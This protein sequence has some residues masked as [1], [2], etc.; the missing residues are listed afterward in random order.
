MVN[1]ID[2]AVLASELKPFAKRIL[3]QYKDLQATDAPQDAKG[4]SSYHLAGKAALSH[5]Q[6]LLEFIQADQADAAEDGLLTITQ[7]AR[8]SFDGLG[9][10]DDT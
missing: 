3:D 4:F 1:D 2:H 8:A 9:G 6:M 7:E 10:Y 5:L